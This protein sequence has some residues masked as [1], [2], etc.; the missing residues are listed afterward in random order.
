MRPVMILV[1]LALSLVPQAS[2]DSRNASA[3]LM[4]PEVE[5]LV[6]P[7]RTAATILLSTGSPIV[8]DAYVDNLVEH[9]ARDRDEA[10]AC[11]AYMAGVRD[12]AT[13]AILPLDVD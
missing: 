8:L 9:K 11:G 12:M 10:L 6:G 7:C 3:K 2:A 13:G 4:T 5:R 1:V